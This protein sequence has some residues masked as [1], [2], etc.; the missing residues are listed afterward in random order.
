MKVGPIAQVAFIAA[1]AVTV[2]GFVRA[3]QN[4]QRYSAC[5][6]VCQM[7]P[8][9]AARDRI[10]PDFELPDLDGKPVRLSQFRGKTVFLNFWTK[11]CRPCLEEMPSLLELGKVVQKRSD[12]VLLAVSTDENPADVKDTLKVVLNEEPSFRVLIDPDA[13]IVRDVFG[14]RLFPETWI[15][16]GKGVIRARFDG[17]RDWSEATV[18][19]I[20]EMVQRT[21]GCPVE[22]FKGAPRGKFAGLCPDEG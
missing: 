17:A 14:T 15:I 3:A 22:F 19:N 8:D 20:G 13:K 7:R 2:Y 16:D 21:G 12:M 5:T 18:I 4:D 6:A 11:T 10:A 1:A 9:Y